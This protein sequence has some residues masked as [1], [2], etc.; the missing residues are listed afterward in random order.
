MQAAIELVPII[1]LANHADEPNMDIGNF[2]TE[3][4]CTI[5]GSGF[6]H[7][8]PVVV[9]ATRRI[10]AGDEVRVLCFVMRV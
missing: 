7:S 5:V 2:E 9:T 4:T 6:A 8:S 3:R 1:D 10:K